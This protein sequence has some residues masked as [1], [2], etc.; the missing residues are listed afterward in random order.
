LHRR[1]H[2][3][4][5]QYPQEKISVTNL[6]QLTGSKHRQASHLKAAVLGC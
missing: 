6:T 5:L 2:G 3:Q 4:D 1:R